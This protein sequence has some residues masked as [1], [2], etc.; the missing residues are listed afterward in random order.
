MV[1]LG[2]ARLTESQILA[3]IA[4]G[5]RHLDG[6]RLYGN[7]RAARAAASGCS[8]GRDGPEDCAL[9]LS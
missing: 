8:T 9:S 3:G 7:E 1:G 2:C 4:N 6:A 5:A